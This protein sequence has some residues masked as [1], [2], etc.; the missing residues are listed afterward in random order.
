MSF[1]DVNISRKQ[2]TFTT[3]VYHKPIFSRIYT[4][5]NNF[6]PSTYK[7]GMIRAL[8]YRRFLICSDR[9]KFQLELF[10][11]MQVFKTNRYAENFINNCLKTYL[12]S[13]H[14]MQ[15]NVITAPKKPLFLFLL[16]LIPLLFQPRTKLRVSLKVTVNCCKL[17]IVFNSQNEKP[18]RFKDCM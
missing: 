6:L 13:K 4:H 11:L 10:K 18:F 12:A 1:L 17:Q 5:F 3:S 8:L 16:Y 9:T 14:K 15:E 7:I 2:S